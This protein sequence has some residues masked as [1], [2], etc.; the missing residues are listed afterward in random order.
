MNPLAH[1]D[2]PDHPVHWGEYLI[3][4][5][6]GL[7]DQEG[8]S[9]LHFVSLA[10]N[11]PLYSS[12]YHGQNLAL[13]GLLPVASVLEFIGQPGGIDGIPYLQRFH[14]KWR[15]LILLRCGLFR[16]H[17]RLLKRWYTVLLHGHPHTLLTR[18]FQGM[19][20]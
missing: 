17:N 19:Q 10:D 7:Q 1:M 20:E 11:D 16:A 2:L 12:G 4:H 5:F 13:I 8:S 14:G 18:Y 15:E 3:S 9:G 6:H